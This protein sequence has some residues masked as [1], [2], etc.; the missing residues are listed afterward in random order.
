MIE[1]DELRALLLSPDKTNP[2]LHDSNHTK[3]MSSSSAPLFTHHRAAVDVMDPHRESLSELLPDEASPTASASV[4]NS[5]KTRDT[6]PDSE[7]RKPSLAERIGF[8]KLPSVRVVHKGNG[9]EGVN[10]DF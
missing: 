3:S 8:E 7:P 4:A 1:L 9:E 2:V 10:E 5:D 6:S